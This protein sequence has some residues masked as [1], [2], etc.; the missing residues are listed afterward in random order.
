[1]NAK[2]RELDNA[3]RI[4]AMENTNFPI[5]SHIPPGYTEKLAELIVQECIHLTAET[6]ASYSLIRR[7]TFDF[8]EKNIYA[9]GEVAAK[10]VATKI[11]QHFGVE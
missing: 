11:K 5:S 8:N 7:V 6:E 1:M 3:A 2:L 10:V 4:W 9:E